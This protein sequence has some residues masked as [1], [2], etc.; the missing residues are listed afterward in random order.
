[1]S[2]IV[3]LPACPRRLPVE[4]SV[5]LIAQLIVPPP[6]GRP[7]LH[8][9]DVC[10]A[11]STPPPTGDH[12]YYL[13]LIYFQQLQNTRRRRETR[14]TKVQADSVWFSRGFDSQPSRHSLLFGF[15][16][17]FKDWI[18][19]FLQGLLYYFTTLLR[20]YWECVVVGTAEY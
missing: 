3:E 10:C 12:Y 19:Q 18:D 17:F 14:N 4:Y 8:R 6:W 7:Y 16:L 5:G 9:G 15:K 13:L 11:L 1:M 20:Y 2:R